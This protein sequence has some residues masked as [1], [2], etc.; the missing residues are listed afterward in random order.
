MP[1][2]SS[3]N[4]LPESPLIEAIARFRAE[5]LA[6]E[7]T[8]AVR[9]VNAY[10]RVYRQL[11]AAIESL[12]EQLAVLDQPTPNQIRRLAALRSL[13]EQI[14]ERVNAFGQFADFELEEGAR[15]AIARGLAHVEQLTLLS[16]PA[17]LQ[18]AVTG[19]FNRLHAAAVETMIGFLAPESPLHGA[20][21]VQLGTAVADAVSDRLIAGIALGYNPRKTA[22]IIRRELGRGLTWSLTTTRTAQLWAYREASRAS[23]IANSDIIRGWVWFS[24]RDVRTCASC[25]AM[26]GSVHKP[27]EVLND[28]HCGRCVAVPLT[29]LEPEPSDKATPGEVLFGR[30]SEQEQR[31]ILGPGKYAAWREGLFDFSALSTE[32]V[33][34][35]YGPMRVETPLKALLEGV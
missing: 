18:P 32:S 27:S 31:A 29:V 10:G 26:H 3:T 25:W 4:P 5:V 23:M 16:V 15:E 2:S 22:A 33:D 34:R 13:R 9:I 17:P 1:N 7:R 28:H 8:R 30:L 12:A 24:A 19:V 14:A 35:V 11:Q 20:L 6:G 21:T